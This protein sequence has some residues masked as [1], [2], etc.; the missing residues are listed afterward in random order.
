MRVGLYSRLFDSNRVPLRE[1]WRRAFEAAEVVGSC[2]EPGPRENGGFC[3]QDMLPQRVMRDGETAWFSAQCV[4]CGH[5]VWCR[6]D[7]PALER[8]SARSGM[9]AGSWDR[10]LKYMKAIEEEGRR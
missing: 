8:S 9:S 1:A 2:R 7:V 4:H 3:G 5:E 6:E 10:R